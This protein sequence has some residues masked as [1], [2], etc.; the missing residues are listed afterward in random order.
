MVYGHI[1]GQIP[2]LQVD[3]EGYAILLHESNCLVGIAAQTWHNH[4]DFSHFNRNEQTSQK[5]DWLISL[6]LNS[7]RK[8]LQ[9]IRKTQHDWLL[10]PL[11]VDFPLKST[12]FQGMGSSLKLCYRSSFPQNAKIKEIWLGL[13]SLKIPILIP[14][15][16]PSYPSK[17]TQDYGTLNGINKYFFYH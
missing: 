13:L 4:S 12:A 8:V 6:F 10:S 16:E 9:W 11:S 7:M 15:F 3:S 17:I 2:V 14:D 5:Q 1:Q